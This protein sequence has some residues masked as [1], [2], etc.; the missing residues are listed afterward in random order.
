MNNTS[1]YATLTAAISNGRLLFFNNL[2]NIT[3]PDICLANPDPFDN[4]TALNSILLTSGHYKIVCTYTFNSLGQP[5]VFPSEPIIHIQLK[6]D[7]TEQNEYFVLNTDPIPSTTQYVQSFEFFLMNPSRGFWNIFIDSPIVNVAE[8][9]F[10]NICAMPTI[11]KQSTVYGMNLYNSYIIKSTTLQANKGTNVKLLC[12]KN[13]IIKPCFVY[14]LEGILRFK[15]PEQNATLI[16]KYDNTILNVQ[17]TICPFSGILNVNIIGE[18]NSECL[19]EYICIQSSAKLV[20][21]CSY[22]VIQ[23][24]FSRNC[25]DYGFLTSDYFLYNNTYIR[26]LFATRDIN[27][28]STHIQDPELFEPRIIQSELYFAKDMCYKILIQC[29]IKQPKSRFVTFGLEGI[30]KSYVYNFPINETTTFYVFEILFHSEICG[31]YSL[32]VS[33]EDALSQSP[34]PYVVPTTTFE[35]IQ[36]YVS[37]T[38]SNVQYNL[39]YGVGDCYQCATIRQCDCELELNVKCQGGVLEGTVRY[40]I[41]LQVEAEEDGDIEVYIIS[42]NKKLLFRKI[43]SPNVLAPKSSVNFVALIPYSPDNRLYYYSDFCLKITGIVII[44]NACSWGD[45][46]A[47]YYTGFYNIN[48]EYITTGTTNGFSTALCNP[49]PFTF[50]QNEKKNCICVKEGYHKIVFTFETTQI[51]FEYTIT[52]VYKKSKNIEKYNTISMGKPQEAYEIITYTCEDQIEILFSA[53]NKINPNQP[54]YRDVPNIYFVVSEIP[55]L[56]NINSPWGVSI[57]Y[58]FAKII[59]N[60]VNSFLCTCI[61]HALEVIDKNE[62]VAQ[63]MRVEIILFVKCIEIQNTSSE[64]VVRYKNTFIGTGNIIIKENYITALNIVLPKVKFFSPKSLS[65]NYSSSVEILGGYFLSQSCY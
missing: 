46:T 63:Y 45:E 60:N 38:P 64:I 23:E 26:S 22:V 34:I 37:E 9:V 19:P 52:L 47:G 6:S 57:L 18:F 11:Y 48:P 41:M 10:V 8:M 56:F 59:P 40:E 14:R 3:S 32:I 21:A 7:K 20:L 36:V 61:D 43:I 54:I 13:N 49:D 31:Y 62:C 35:S 12:S 53:L 2:S 30:E 1:G 24:I 16:V 51:P 58:L 65:F 42:K 4:S 29:E 33:S 17:T 25:G 27:S 55:T 39:S 15:N 44:H 5:I 50:S 28:F